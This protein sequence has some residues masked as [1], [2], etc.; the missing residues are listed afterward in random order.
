MLASDNSTGFAVDGYAD[1]LLHLATDLGRR[2][3]PAFDTPTGVPFGAV[4]L[5]YGVAENESKMTSTAGARFSPLVARRLAPLTV[6]HGHLPAAVTVHCSTCIALS[7]PPPRFLHTHTL[8]GG[9]MCMEF[10]LLSRLTGDDRFEVREILCT[11]SPLTSRAPHHHK[12]P[13]PLATALALTPP[14]PRA[15]PP[16]VR[17]AVRRAA[18]PARPLV[19]PLPPQSRRGSHR[20]RH[21]TQGGNTKTRPDAT[22]A[23]CIPPSG[24]SAPV[25]HRKPRPRRTAQGKWTHRDSGIGTSID[26]F[27]EYLLKC[28]VFLQE[29]E[30]LHMFRQA[31]ARA[32]N[33]AHAKPSKTRP[34]RGRERHHLLTG[35]QNT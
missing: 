6:F 19:P 20:H 32:L 33:H 27:Y 7:E 31:R 12:S 24:P 18:G 17:A 15:L 10:G 35:E 30:Y 14:S 28:H 5:R 9:T 21:G 34:A 11:L 13:R 25:A 3:L 8:G 1:G 23:S 4:N 16:P 29:A 26:S 2:L 22:A